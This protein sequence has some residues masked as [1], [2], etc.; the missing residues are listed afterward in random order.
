MTL[1]NS[2]TATT[3]YGF[4]LTLSLCSERPLCIS[5]TIPCTLFHC[6]A[7]DRYLDADSRVGGGYIHFVSCFISSLLCFQGESKSTA[8]LRDLTEI[9]YVQLIYKMVLKIPLSFLIPPLSYCGNL[10]TVISHIIISL[11]L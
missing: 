10:K 9:Q 2:T 5:Q 11:S 3:L 1:S 8:V 7:G 6:P 4:I